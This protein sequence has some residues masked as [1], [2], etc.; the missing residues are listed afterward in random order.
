MATI[1]QLSPEIRVLTPLGE[2]YALF[3]IDYGMNHNTVWVVALY[4][5]GKILHFD[6]R[7]VK[8]CGNEMLDISEPKPFKERNV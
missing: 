6:S 7:E 4:D 5:D 1:L 2:G 3:I 8:H